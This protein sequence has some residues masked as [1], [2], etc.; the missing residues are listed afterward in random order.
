MIVAFIKLGHADSGIHRRFG[1]DNRRKRG[2]GRRR[3]R[4][5]SKRRRRGC[6]RRYSRGRGDLVHAGSAEDVVDV[7]DDAIADDEVGVEDDDG[8]GGV[9][10]TGNLQLHH[11]PV[12]ARADLKHHVVDRDELKT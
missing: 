1:G 6:H 11:L 5:R 10:A 9:V 3:K 7:V 4:R 12:G 2:R 8:G